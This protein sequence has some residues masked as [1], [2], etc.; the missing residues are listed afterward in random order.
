MESTI[1]DT[2]RYV[3]LITRHI[4]RGHVK[5]AILAVLMDL[6]FQENLDGF[7]F[8]RRAIDIR[9]GDVLI[10]MGAIYLM[11]AEQCGMGPDTD[12]I[13][14]NIRKSI[15]GAWQAGRRE[16]WMLV[17]PPE[18]KQTGKGPTNGRFISRVVCLMELWCSCS[19]EVSH[20][21]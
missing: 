20:A 3:L 8:T 14:Q 13:D 21:G 4:K 15:T 9:M 6:G 7:A 1:D 12:P 17:C 5:S 18:G 11:I 19:E 2:L 10:R 16:K